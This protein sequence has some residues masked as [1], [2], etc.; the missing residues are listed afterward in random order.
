MADLTQRLLHDEART[1][2][3]SGSDHGAQ[4]YGIE[5]KVERLGADSDRVGGLVRFNAAES[6]RSDAGPVS[7]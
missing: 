5:V 7:D 2:G 1:G 4:K 3:G 6:E